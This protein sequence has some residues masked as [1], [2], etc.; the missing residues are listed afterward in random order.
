[1]G[2]NLE[3][4]TVIESENIDAVAEV[5]WSMLGGRL[6]VSHGASPPAPRWSAL[7]EMSF[8]GILG[9]VRAVASE[10]IVAYFAGEKPIQDCDCSMPEEEL[11]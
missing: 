10:A 3:A 6:W 9:E 7:K 4:P 11:R 2:K 8:P 5:I 1:M